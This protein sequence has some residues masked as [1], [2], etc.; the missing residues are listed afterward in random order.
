MLVS[1]FFMMHRCKSALSIRTCRGVLLVLPQCV[2]RGPD[3]R[4]LYQT[5]CLYEPVERNIPP[6]SRESASGTV[7]SFPISTGFTNRIKM[8]T[9]PHLIIYKNNGHY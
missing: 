8:K 6:E 4:R 1:D 7:C 2:I 9:P 5:E 3:C